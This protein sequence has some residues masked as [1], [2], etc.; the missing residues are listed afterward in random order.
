ML[1]GGNIGQGWN[2]RYSLLS[3]TTVSHAACQFRTYPALCGY[4][5][6]S[7][8]VKLRDGQLR[9]GSWLI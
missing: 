9:D 8:R 4:G 5:G 3:G 1:Q 2:I 6:L 7:A